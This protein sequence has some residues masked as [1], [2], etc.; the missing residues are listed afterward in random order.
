MTRKISFLLLFFASSVSIVLGSPA[1]NV[2]DL[3]LANSP[4]VV[5]GYWPKAK[6]IDRS[7]RIGN[8]IEQPETLTKLIVTKVLHG[9]ITPGTLE[10]MI[11]RFLWWDSKNGSFPN[12]ATSTMEVSSVDVSKPNI[13]F[14]KRSRSWRKSDRSSYLHAYSLHCIQPLKLST[15]FE[16]MRGP[17]YVS[18]LRKCLQSSDEDVTERAM[19]LV[20]GE[21]PAWPDFEDQSH[22]D[23]NSPAG[24]DY[25]PKRIVA[26]LADVLNLAQ[27]RGAPNRHLAI[28]LYAE[29]TGEKSK[30][31]LRQLLDDP[32]AKVRVTAAAWLVRLGDVASAQITAEAIKGFHEPKL[33]CELIYAME[34]TGKLEYVPALL[35]F[36]DYDDAGGAIDDDW[37]IPGLYARRA[38]KKLT[39]F[40]FPLDS[41][42][43]TDAWNRIGANP[44]KLTEALGSWENPLKVSCKVVRTAEGKLKPVIRKKDDGLSRP[45]VLAVTLTNQTGHPIPLLQYPST[46]SIHSEYGGGVGGTGFKD[47]FVEMGPGSSRIFEIPVDTYEFPSKQYEI[48]MCFLNNGLKEGKK[49]WMGV[50]RSSFAL[51]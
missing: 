29:M 5:M 35:P 9:E 37:E 51:N 4:I 28:G 26:L 2:S 45:V 6:M 7:Q 49:A 19:N 10:L 50:L 1:P 13:W 32:V 47:R 18:G 33:S 17:N 44:K 40:E 16:L 23:G 48:S 41:K 42:S 20:S 24:S 43:S 30:P 12:S 25:K 36:L 11:Q 34:K 38:L 22:L 46:V 21:W 31:I 3:D 15:Y 8:V 27:R 39:A 14:L